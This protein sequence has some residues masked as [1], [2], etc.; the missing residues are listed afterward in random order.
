M[1]PSGEMVKK[2]L[3]FTPKSA[4]L[5][6]V[7]R[8]KIMREKKKFLNVVFNIKR[9]P[10]YKGNHELAGFNG[11]HT[12]FPLGTTEQEMIDEFH[13]ETVVKDI[14]G[15]TWTKGEMIQVVSIEKCFE[16]WCD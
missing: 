2:V 9:N 5:F 10:D 7:M 6:E 15:K 8:E 14:H 3:D 13:A 4:I 12:T 1:V 16:D 11:I